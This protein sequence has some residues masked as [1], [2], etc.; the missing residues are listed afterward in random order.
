VDLETACELDID[1]Y[2]IQEEGI[3][4]EFKQCEYSEITSIAFL[5]SH[6]GGVQYI[7]ITDSGRVRGVRLD[8]ECRDRLRIRIGSSLFDIGVDAGIY[9]Q[10]RFIPIRYHNDMYVVQIRILPFTEKP[11]IYDI[12]GTAYIRQISQNRVLNGPML[13][14]R[15]VEFEK[16]KKQR[17]QGEFSCT[18]L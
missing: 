16:K 10:V 5:N 4:V 11:A 9:S 14:N 3:D 7:G 8:Y 18:I 15:I 2:V 13:E 17:Q 12:N 6:S 1:S